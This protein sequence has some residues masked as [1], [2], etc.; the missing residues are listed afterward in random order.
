MISGIPLLR[1]ARFRHVVRV[2]NT[3]SQELAAMGALQRQAWKQALKYCHK[4]S[5]RNICVSTGVWTDLTANFAADAANSSVIQNPVDL[6]YMSALAAQPSSF[7]DSL[8]PGRKLILAIGRLTPQK[9]FATLIRAF[10][11]LLNSSARPATL[12]IAGEGPQRAALESLA[13]EL[14]IRQ[15][16]HLPGWIGNPF[17]IYKAADAFVLSSRF[18]GM[19]NVI[20]EAL[21]FG[22]P[23]VATDCP[24]GPR[25]ILVDGSLGDLVPIGDP[26]TMAAR[27]DAALA[28]GKD[29]R[30]RAHVAR[31]FALDVVADKYERN[32]FDA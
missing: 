21:A 13:S 29:E 9:D 6:H 22:L 2:A 32:I 12:V 24:S 28:H 4:R 26:A 5:H 17:P 16:V 31:H 3:Y 27:L 7:L 10:D 1:G 8:S 23:V 25:E 18:E 19:P 11:V 20:L 14:G 15:H 30:R